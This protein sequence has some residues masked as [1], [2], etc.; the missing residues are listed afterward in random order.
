MP[1]NFLRRTQLLIDRDVQVRLSVRLALCLLGYVL[2]FC[3]ISLGEP[4]LVLLGAV[5]TDLTKE[6]ALQIIYRFSSTILAPLLFAVACMILHGVL[7]LHRLAGPVF[8]IRKALATLQDGDLTDR[9]HLRHRDYLVDLA[10]TYNR[11]V[12]RLSRDLEDARAGLRSAIERKPDDAVRKDLQRVDQ[13]L[14]KYWLPED[15]EAPEKA[16]D[17]APEQEGARSAQSAGC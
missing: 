4:L 17:P 12:E 13:I 3:L 7:I 1:F 10:A 14:E 8:R 5:E 11:S 16:G 15:E 9:I 2:M 6:M